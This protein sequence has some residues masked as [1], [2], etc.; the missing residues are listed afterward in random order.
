MGEK[1][2]GKEKEI[3]NVFDMFKQ[4][5]IPS[6]EATTVSA[7]ATGLTPSVSMGVA[8]VLGVIMGALS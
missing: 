7:A 6:V 1:R 5:Y 4:S 2:K 8:P 3:I